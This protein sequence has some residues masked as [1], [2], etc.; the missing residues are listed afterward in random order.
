MLQD[1]KCSE[2]IGSKGVRM[3]ADNQGAIA[4]TKNLYLHERSRHIDI[5]YHYVRDLVE[6]GKLR[7]KYV[8]IT[9]I[10][11]DRFT[12]PLERTAFNRFIAQ[13]GMVEKS[14]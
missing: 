9:K 14:L 11:A 2:F 5:K 8:P 6:Q 10:V 4:L 13:L 3:L 12:K 7:I 1:L